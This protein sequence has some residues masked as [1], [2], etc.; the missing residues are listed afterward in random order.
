VPAINRTITVTGNRQAV[1]DFLSDFTNTEAWD[2]P[3]QSTTRESGDG[4]VGT[5]YHNVSKLLGR[6]TE[7]TYRVIAH[8]APSRL[9][10]AGEAGP[11]KLHD[12]IRLEQD[13]DQVHVHYRAEFTPQGLAKLMVPL[14]PLGLK[15]LGDDAAAQMQDCLERL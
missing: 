3:T 10:L 2:P 12:T 11:M 13:G 4:S 5:V 7:V 8:D 6:R 14:L 1:W 15:K 9:E